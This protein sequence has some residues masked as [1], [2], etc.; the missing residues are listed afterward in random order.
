MLLEQT[1]RQVQSSGVMQTARA[2]IK[3]T[4]KIFS[5]FEDGTYANKP[6]AICRELVSN[7][8]DSHTA[9]GCST[10]PVEVTVPNELDPVFKVRDFGIGMSHVF[11]MGDE[12]TPSKFMAYTD[13]STKD[14]SNDQIGGFGI[15]SKS[16]F[17]YTDQFTI[18]SVHNGMLGV[19]S[20]YKGEDGVPEIG[21]LGLVTTDESNG[22][23]VSFPV[24]GEDIDS[25]CEAA[26]QALQ[27][28]K[29]LPIV[30]GMTLNPPDYSYEAMT[31]GLRPQPGELGVIMG[32]VRYPVSTDNLAYSLRVSSRLSPLLGY[33][34]DLFLPIGA[35]NVAMSREALSYKG[36]TSK[37]IEAALAAVIDDVI[38]TFSTMFDDC[39]SFWDAQVKLGKEVGFNTY[40]ASPRA[41]LLGANARY[42]GAPLT[43]ELSVRPLDRPTAW[44][45]HSRHTRGARKSLMTMKWEPLSQLST[46]QPGNIENVI[47]DDLPQSPKSKTSRKIREFL[48]T[49]DLN[50]P[51]LVLRA[52]DDNT[53]PAKIR[54]LLIELG[55]PSNY[56]LTS[57]LP[58][59]AKI[60]RV[61]TERPRVRM[62]TYN[63][64]TDRNTRSQP[65]NL[66]PSWS[67][68]EIVTEIE[69]KNQPT[70]G[71]LVT[72]RSFDLPGR[73]Y[74][75]MRTKLIDF[76]ELHFVN[77][78]DAAKLKDTWQS[79]DAV[80]Q[81]RLDAAL[82]QH[83]RLP[84]SL[85]LSSNQDLR[86]LFS[87]A[88]VVSSQISLTP[89]Q[90]KRPFGRILTLWRECI[91]PI[92]PAQRLLAPFVTAVLPAGIHPEKLAA[93]FYNEQD[94]A[95]ILFSCLD[96]TASSHLAL[97]C[98]HL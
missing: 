53:L 9:A 6:L 22:V 43:T 96:L 81:E 19:Y 98:K 39:A 29:P 26:Q 2:T 80:F 78:G 61:K 54:M 48:E 73:F 3:A 60:E 84:E 89:S 93:A 8:V 77:E 76:D 68:K 21:C 64:G 86:E 97:L 79:F 87:R 75:M 32:G 38:A 23:E 11:M 45:I 71:I 69:Y 72:M 49:F 63:G 1:N 16:P 94:E 33:G 70:T 59:P 14:M 85:A 58:E 13:G 65:D 41:K 44:W 25:F 83:S 35:C 24:K 20:V 66:T 12:T 40:S 88:A 52:E 27:Y 51:T 34:L 95:D 4:P 56:T 36:D 5:M 74:E 18:R 30:H 91:K 47:I 67:K 37:N 50:K 57:S 31:W 46:L 55:N 15:G 28:F 10:R 42:K 82:K 17:A 92:T 7:G 62:W 90:L